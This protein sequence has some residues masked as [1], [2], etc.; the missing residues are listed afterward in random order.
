MSA[1]GSWPN[2]APPAVHGESSWTWVLQ[3]P[4]D[5]VRA[6]TELFLHLQA[7][8]P[9]AVTMSAIDAL[10]VAF[11]ELAGNALTHVGGP[12][13]AQVHRAPLVGPLPTSWL[14]TVRDSAPRRPPV[15]TDPTAAGGCGLHLVHAVSEDCGWIVVAPTKTVWALITMPGT[16]TSLSPAALTETA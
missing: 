13:L 4:A 10:L 12:V 14:V 6:R 9:C 1:S 8:P 5:L 15:P 11:D 7:P 2:A 16:L 3:A